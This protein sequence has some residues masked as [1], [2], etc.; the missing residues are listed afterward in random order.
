MRSEIR[1]AVVL[2]LLLT[3]LTG[4]VYPLAVTGIARLAFP[5]AS[6]G[7]L[8]VHGGRVVGSR[9]IGQSFTQPGYFWGRV[10]STTP[11][12]DAGASSGANLGPTNPELLARVRTRI[13]A[14]R[15]ADPGAGALV[16]VDLVTSSASGLD[17]HVS[18]AA[19]EFQVARVARA[20]G[21]AP[22]AVRALVAA[23]VHRP[24]PAWAGEPV[25]DVLG[26]NLALDAAAPAARLPSHARLPGARPASGW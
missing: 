25:V 18:P 19:A 7:S 23:H 2:L 13:E 14:L 16:P 15:A 5:A 11:P 26:L 9:L 21:L 12:F 10:P 8:V 17:P 22:A 1:S 20:R 6:R 3:F 4:I 24:R